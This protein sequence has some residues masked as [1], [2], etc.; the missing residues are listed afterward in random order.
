MH[1]RSIDMGQIL[2]C[3][4]YSLL[5]LSTAV[6]IEIDIEIEIEIEIEIGSVDPWS[7]NDA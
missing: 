4:Y 5:C 7:N 1:A 3:F 6:E 2:Y